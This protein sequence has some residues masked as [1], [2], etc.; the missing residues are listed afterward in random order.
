MHTPLAAGVVLTGGRSRRMGGAVKALAPL[1]GKPM[2][3]HVIDRVR[4]QVSELMLSVEE[5]A[6]AFEFLKLEQVPD[7]VPGSRGPL[8]GLFSALDR[9][10]SRYDWLLL[11]PCDAPFVPTDLLEKLLRQALESKKPG[12]V[13]SIATEIQPTFSIWHR[14]LL[15]D[16]E[17]AVLEQE[18]AGFKQFLDVVKLAV[19]EWPL[20]D[21]SSFFNINDQEAL[22]RADRLMDPVNRTRGS[23]SA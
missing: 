14:S 1:A 15:P 5:P 20:T 6:R 7:R 21:I 9:M 13:V 11:A 10:D 23:C 8:G 12:A 4:P 22:D 19:F 3:Q 18:M 16:L 2:I 17:R